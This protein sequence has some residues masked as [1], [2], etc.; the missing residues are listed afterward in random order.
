MQRCSASEWDELMDLVA[1][2]LIGESRADLRQAVAVT[3]IGNLL[4]SLWARKGAKKMKVEDNLLSAMIGSDD[5][6]VQEMSAQ[7]QLEAAQRAIAALKSPSGPV[8]RPKT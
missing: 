8:L 7:E 1:E 4:I 6:E 2:D 5:E 3:T